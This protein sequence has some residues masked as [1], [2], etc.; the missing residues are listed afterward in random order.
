MKK[1]LYIILSFIILVSCQNIETKSSLKDKIASLEKE[2]SELHSGA[3]KMADNIDSYRL[4]LDELDV[5][6]AALDQHHSKVI[7][8]STNYKDDVKIKDDIKEHINYLNA[9]LSNL[10]LRS[11]H[12]H[13][14]IKELC[15]NESLNAD[16][17]EFLKLEFDI[18]VSKIVKRNDEIEELRQS[19]KANDKENNFL[20]KELKENELYT[21]VLYE[22]IH[23]KFYCI[24]S[25]DEL[26]EKGIIVDENLKSNSH[27]YR[28][29]AKANDGLFTPVFAD[30]TDTIM[31][32]S[33]SAKLLSVHP[34][35]SYSFIGG[36]TLTGLYINDYKKFWD[37]SEFLIV[38][39]D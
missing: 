6:I 35:D 38:Q 20:D 33:K 23:T 10:K 4:M 11:K 1:V 24:G 19:I 37:K 15:K 3:A 17:L 39:I 9:Q 32:N 28:L 26:L 7:T 14:N 13:N 8:L 25:A 12:L 5:N 18:A 36:D 2:N 21:S 34:D 30:K 22:I 29:N 27:L 31:F 16:S